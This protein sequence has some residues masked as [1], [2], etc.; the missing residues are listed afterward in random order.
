MM[1]CNPLTLKMSNGPFEEKILEHQILGPL[2][3]LGK[4]F[5]IRPFCCLLEID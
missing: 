1:D 4:F 2:Q 5:T 3:R